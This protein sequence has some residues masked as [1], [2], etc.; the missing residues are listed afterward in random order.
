[1]IMEIK[2]FLLHGNFLLFVKLKQLNKE[3]IEL[4]GMH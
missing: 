2:I 3:E 1:M 4:A